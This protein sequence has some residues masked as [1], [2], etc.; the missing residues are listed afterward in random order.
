[1]REHNWLVKNLDDIFKGLGGLKFG[2]TYVRRASIDLRNRSLLPPHC[3]TM[4]RTNP[5]TAS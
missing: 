2:P 4:T 1:M 5:L 3:S